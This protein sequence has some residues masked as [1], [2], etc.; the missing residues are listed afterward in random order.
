M[1]NL[2]IN[3]T[4]TQVLAICDDAACATQVLRTTWTFARND[5]LGITTV[6]VDFP[7]DDPETFLVQGDWDSIYGEAGTMAV[8]LNDGFSLTADNPV[9]L[10]P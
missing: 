6:V 8:A 5:D 4:L 3:P 2:L 10:N 7:I 9:V 1:A